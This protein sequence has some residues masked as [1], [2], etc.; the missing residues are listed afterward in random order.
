MNN[1]NDYLYNSD[2]FDEFF[3]KADQEIAQ[4]IGR[5]TGRNPYNILLDEIVDNACE[6]WDE[7]INSTIPF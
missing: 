3:L 6:I 2:N 5:E 7:Y 1:I 4:M